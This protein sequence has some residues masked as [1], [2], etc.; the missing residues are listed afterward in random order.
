MS[1][2]TKVVQFRA[3]PKSQAKLEELK[4]RLKEKGVKPSIEVVLNSMLE[5]VTMAFFDKCVSQL[6]SENSVKTQLLKMHKEGRITEEML[7]SLLKN[8]AESPDN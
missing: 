2:K 5:N 4:A 3:T 1:D 7:N 6:V 8:T